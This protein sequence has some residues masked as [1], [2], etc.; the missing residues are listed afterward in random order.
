MRHILNLSLSSSRYSSTE[1]IPFNDDTIRLTQLGVD[2]DTEL[3][4]SLLRSYDG[5]VD[6]ICINYLPPVVNL[7]RTILRHEIYDTVERAVKET[8][9]YYGHAL[10]SIL[11]DWSIRKAMETGVLNVRNANLLFNSGLVMHEMAKTLDPAALST[12]YADAWTFLGL[13]KLFPNL[14]DLEKYVSYTAR[15]LEKTP[16]RDRKSSRLKTTL[17]GDWYRKQVRVAD[18]IVS[19]VRMLE[20]MDLTIYKGKTLLLDT[21]PKEMAQKLRDAGV[22]NAFYTEPRIEGVEGTYSYAVTEALI[23]ILRGQEG[24]LTQEDIIDFYGEQEIFSPLCQLDESSPEIPRKYAFIIH[25]LSRDDL[26]RHPAGRPFKSMPEG[27]KKQVEHGLALAPGFLYGRITGVRSEATG[28]CADGLIYTLFATPKEMVSARPESIYKLLLAIG[29]D[30]V[31]RGAKI[32]GLGAFTK[33]VGDAGVTVA[34][35]ASL[36]VTTGNSLSAAATLWAA[37]EAC[38]KMG[39]LELIPGDDIR[40]NNTVMVIGATGSIGKACTSVL[41]ASFNTVIIAAINVPRLMSYK[42][43][44][45][46]LYP[47][48]K[49]IVTTQPERYADQC[50]LIVVSTSATEGGAFTLDNVKPGCVICDVSRPLTFSA[51]VAMKRPDVL[52]I[53]SGEIELPG[54]NVKVSCDL[55]LEK[56]VVYAC[57]AETALLALE[58]RYESFTLSRN[59]NYKKV[60]EIYKIARKHGA[61]LAQIRSPN[62]EITDQEI[63]LCREH[64]FAALKNWKKV[65]NG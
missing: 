31:K 40:V 61:R 2:F 11:F 50:D 65:S 49:I 57:L 64:A 35:R 18:I 23:A 42:K 43:E 28:V 33:I 14:R 45:Q 22:K 60:K 48:I 41:G 17:V 10:K 47:N 15:L 3:F 62:G 5:K 27:L 46:T 21:L 13:P 38:R 44:L 25:P 34:A 63:E 52:V 9:I 19:P 1:L 6:A 29:D 39:F 30:A 36:P 59:V 12:R 7:R 20:T 4:E 53:E 51:E 32:M 8:P 37:K 56:N 55:G 16:I 58:G 54:D 24:V 26:F